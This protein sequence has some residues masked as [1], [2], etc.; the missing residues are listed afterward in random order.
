MSGS[1]AETL[2]SRIVLDTSLYSQARRGS[3]LALN[4]IVQAEIVF[5]PVTVLGELEAGFRLG[6]RYRENRRALD[7]FVREPYVRVLEVTADIARLYGEVFAALRAAGTPVP[8]N[9]IWIA[10]TTLGCGGHLVS[11]DEAFARIEGL[12]LTVYAH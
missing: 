8:V 11:F 3:R 6:S 4:A 12:P 5:V 2:P 7:E 1:G 10:A 9:D